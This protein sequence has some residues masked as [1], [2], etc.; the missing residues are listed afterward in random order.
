MQAEID[1]SGRVE[2]TNRATALALANDVSVCI[3]ISAK[4]KQQLIKAML[5][6][7]SQKRTVIH[8]TIFST[9]LFLLLREHVEK[10]DLVAIDPEYPG[11]EPVIKNQLLGHCENN[12][13]GVDK[14]CIYFEQV[15]KKSPAHDLAIKVYQ[16]KATAD[17]VVTAKEILE[18]L[19]G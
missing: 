18:L 7:K 4:E 1:M 5:K 15:G 11:Y 13:L 10:L 14:E 6:R 17:R 12:E 16:G 19:G 3:S 8:V 9:L 2:E